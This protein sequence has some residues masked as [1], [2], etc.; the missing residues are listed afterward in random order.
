MRVVSLLP[1]AT[2]I[3]AALGMLDALVAVSHECDFPPAVAA[4][5]RATRC[6]IHGNALPSADTDAWVRR[7]LAERGTLYTLDEALLRRLDPTVIVTQRLCDVC[8]VE[9]ETVTAFAA[10]LPSRPAVVNLEPERLADVLGD[11]RRVGQA[12]GVAARAEA[13]VEA[14]EAR[15][16]ALRAR[17]AGAVRPRCALLEWVD[18]PYRGGHWMPELVDAAGATDLLGRVGEKA[19]ATDWETVR[20]AEPELLVLACCGYDVSR[21]LADLPLLEA[22]PGWRDI[23]AVRAGRVWAVNGSA[24]FSRPGPRLVDSAELLGALAHPERF[25]APPPDAA[26]AL[27]PPR[28]V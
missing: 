25:P 6:E 14:L 4:T 9:Y 27:P 28:S 20:A 5:P 22:V 16:A 2:E 10:T 24:Y 23:P 12:L 13:V 1:A 15:L 17:V 18:P 19:V 7:Q 21:T 3:I 26:R 11:V 8:A